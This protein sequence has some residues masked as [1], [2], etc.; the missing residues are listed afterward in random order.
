MSF[1][2]SL[3]FLLSSIRLGFLCHS[4]EPFSSIFF[5]KFAKHC[6][7]L[8]CLL[9]TPSFSFFRIHRNRKLISDFLILSYQPFHPLDSFVDVSTNLITPE[10]TEREAKKRVKFRLL[11]PTTKQIVHGAGNPLHSL[12]RK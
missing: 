8:L 7:H 3:L 2:S 5:I 10:E 4:R 6:H 9:V 1:Q 11:H 12:L